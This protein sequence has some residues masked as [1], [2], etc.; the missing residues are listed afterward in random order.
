MKQYEPCIQ[1]NNNNN[2]TN[3]NNN[4]YKN[5]SK[6]GGGN[7]FVERESASGKSNRRFSPGLK[8]KLIH[9]ARATREYQNLGVSSDSMR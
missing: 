9:P 7:L 5:E 2:N 8:T 4:K 1:N 3:N 6:K